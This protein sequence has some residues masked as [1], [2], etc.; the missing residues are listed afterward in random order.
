MRLRLLGSRADNI[1]SILP[2][3]RGAVRPSSMIVPEQLLCSK[4]KKARRQAEIAR[5]YVAI[6]EMRLPF[7]SG[8]EHRG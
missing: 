1:E 2:A 5:L 8:K 4:S 3:S 6:I 7:A